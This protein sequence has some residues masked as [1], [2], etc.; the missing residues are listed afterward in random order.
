[1]ASRNA[2]NTA[3]AI[4][5]PLHPANEEEKR[6]YTGGESKGDFKCLENRVFHYKYIF[7]LRSKTT[8]NSTSKRIDFQSGAKC[9]W[10]KTNSQHIYENDGFKW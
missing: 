3:A 1:M 10:A 9:I 8:A 5:N 2:T 7:Y 6:I 4:V